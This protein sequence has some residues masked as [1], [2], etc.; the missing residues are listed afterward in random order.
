MKWSFN[1]KS[2]DYLME[3]KEETIRLDLKT[4]GEI[5]E[6]QALWAG[7][8]PGMRV[9]DLGFGSGKTSYHLYKVV[10]PEG[11]VVAVDISKDR[12]IYANHN[13]KAEGI[14]YIQRDIREPLDDLGMFD[15]IWIRFVLEY[16]KSKG[17]KIVENVFRILKPGGI[18]T[19]I[20]L[21]HNCLS[22]YGLPGRLEKTFFEIA[23]ILQSKADF[24]PYMGRKLYSFLYDLGFENININMSPHHLIFGKLKEVDAYNWA[25]KAQVAVK[26]LGYKFSQYKGGYEEFYQ[27]FNNFFADPRRFTYTPLILCS[28]RKPI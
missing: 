5:V 6:K 23:Y 8:R 1:V 7:I 15:F 28:G 20:D 25:K 26:Q 3:N 13:Y 9:A 11:E 21:D 22:H 18:L 12:I 14:N 27:D 4:D 24:D 2:S 16:Y 19:L 10:Q 17:F